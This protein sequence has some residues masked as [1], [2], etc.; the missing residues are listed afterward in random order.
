MAL[1]L[2]GIVNSSPNAALAATMLV[3]G[4][5][6][7]VTKAVQTATA[8]GDY[9]DYGDSAQN[10][11]RV[12]AAP[13]LPARSASSQGATFHRDIARRIS[14]CRIGRRPTDRLPDGPSLH[15]PHA[16]T[17]RRA[18]LSQTHHL[19]RRANHLHISAY[20]GSLKRDVSRSSRAS[21]RKMRWARCS[22]AGCQSRAD[23]QSE[24]TAKWCGPGV[25]KLTSSRR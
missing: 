19:P 10:T 7:C 2:G 16:P 5:T 13:S 12:S 8:G 23:G 4:A 9:G 24:A 1:L 25:P 18:S 11:L 21:S 22:A 15:T 6:L 3:I 17:A 14:S 20:P